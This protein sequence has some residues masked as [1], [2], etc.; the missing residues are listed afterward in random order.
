MNFVKYIALLIVSP[1]EG[2]KDINKYTIPNNL[3]LSKLYY[4][5]L[6]ILSLSVF[7][8]FLFGDGSVGLNGVILYALID[9]VKYFI[10]FFAISYLLT[11]IY[12]NVFKS[13]NEINKLN[14]Y[15][16]FNLAILVLF[17]VLRNFMPGFPF[18]E[19]FPL[20]IIFVI[21]KGINYVA[22]P[23]A[24]HVKFII[25]SSLFML[26]IPVGIKFVLELLIPNF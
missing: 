16:V 15:V 21:Y 26:L 12:S 6:A 3:L 10:S 9:F 19:I 4:P 1:S 5:V 23:Q 13:K 17:N 7:V 11:G 25:L 14:N 22:V 2:W 24:E 20:Y 8:P 18:F